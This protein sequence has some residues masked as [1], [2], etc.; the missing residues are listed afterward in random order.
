LRERETQGKILMLKL[1]PVSDAGLDVMGSVVGFALMPVPPK[2]FIAA[3]T[4]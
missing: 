1:L 4:L 2:M 3:G